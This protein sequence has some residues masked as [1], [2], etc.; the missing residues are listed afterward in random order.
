[1]ARVLIIDDDNT[2]RK[3]LFF[4]LR[5][6][7]EEV[8]QAES[9]I[10]AKKL[11]ASERFDVIISD[12]R[13]PE[14]KDGINLV[15]NIKQTHP[16][17]PTLMITAFGSVDSAVKA[18]KAGAF[19]YLTKDFT[20]EEIVLK[21]K[22]MLE[23]RKLWLSNLRLSQE[24]NALKNQNLIQ[25]NNDEII[26]NSKAVT[27]ILELVKRI[28]NDK[29][30]TI[31]L[32]GESG[33]GKELIAKSIHRNTPVRNNNNFIVVDVASMPTTLLESQLFGHEK[34]AFT[35]AK[36]R[37]IGY[38]E[39]A[40]NG[41]V[42]LDEIGDFPLELQ[43]KLLRFL[44]EKTFV[45]VGGVEQIFTDVRIIAATNRDLESMIKRGEFRNDLYYR[46][47]VVNI[48]LP[49]L[50]ERPEDILV[51]L[52]YY[53]KKFETTKNRKL[54]FPETVIDKMVNYEWPGNIRQLKNLV[55]SLY[56]L[57]PFD[58]VSEEDL[59]FDNSE[60]NIVFDKLPES[61]LNLSFKDARQRILEKFEY[62]YIKFYWEKYQG[63]ISKIASHV[64][65]SREGLS[66][67]IKNYDLKNI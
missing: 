6:F 24:V 39:E 16:L 57:A 17:T 33:T 35:D 51:L 67:K 56:V 60:S 18:I 15:K 44:Q 63:N 3:G 46:L 11:L 58:E 49:P 43:V 31:L 29:D 59:Q 10:D 25:P 8:L 48:N 45:R 21:V 5:S 64:G 28:G 52:E 27:K 9:V 62:E 14:E 66:K 2:A 30:S 38:F 26:G 23:T 40:R 22:K 41:T 7:V 37:H 47:K 65:V 55:E 42:F 1:M 4:I 34:G 20:K 13:L 19:D 50:R 61:L 36:E 53:T 32:Q 54:V 12:L